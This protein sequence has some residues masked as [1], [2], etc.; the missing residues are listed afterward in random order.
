MQAYGWKRPQNPRS[1]GETVVVPAWSL[2]VMADGSVEPILPD[3]V[4]FRDGDLIRPICPFIEVWARI[5]DP[6]R[7][8]SEWRD[9]PLTPS[10]IEAEGATLADLR[11]SVTAR[12]LKAA[13]RADDARLAFGTFP[14][15]ELRA[16]RHER[17]AVDGT[18]PPGATPPMIPANRSIPLGSIQV[19]RSRPQPAPGSVEWEESVNVETIRLRF[20]PAR[21]RFYG[22]PQA[23]VRT[24]ASDIPAVTA[25]NAFLDPAAGWFGSSGNVN[26]FVS[27]ADTIDETDR[28]SG[29][30][31]GGVD[32]TCE[33][34]IDV[35]LP[36]P[37]GGVHRTHANIFVA[38]PDFA[39][40]RRPFLSV[41]D[42]L[43]DRVGNATE[44]NAAMNEDELSVW[45][46]D[47]F[48]RVYEH[49]SLMNVDHWRG[50]H[51]IQLPGSALLTTPLEG[52]NVLPG[53]RA[54]GSRDRLRNRALRVGPST[55]NDPLPLSNHAR[56][57][58]RT[59]SDADA[60]RK[61]VAEKPSRLAE[62][63]RGPFEVEPGEGGGATTMRMPP[64]MRQSTAH[65]L[66]LA[67][68]QYA[69]LME[70]VEQ[71]LAGPVVLALEPETD[72]L[73]RAEA[74]RQEVLAGLPPTGDAQ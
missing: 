32:D 29:V 48:E 28:G 42:E 35:R 34:R 69:L 33:L 24:D 70:W 57:R 74:R 31:L 50:R 39:P 56:E 51:A 3:T 13:R 71:V 1:D 63:V 53:D 2:E 55:S 4:I 15:L 72:E 40:D 27:P 22:P 49:V 47:L 64:F 36:N 7:P 61:L 30:S 8:P 52:D 9:T 21:G 10:L 62:I 25:A 65:T 20:T 17:R 41:A 68:W 37:A 67:A 11:F 59:L 23:A 16:D 46:A 5:G 44:R 19:M 66:T 6:S 73:D 26:G 43:N 38:P 54:M 58:H 18:S 45:V 60:L 14:D 12:N